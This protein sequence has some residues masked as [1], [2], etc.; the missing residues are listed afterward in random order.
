[1]LR[2]RSRRLPPVRAVTA[3]SAA[4]LYGCRR[5]ALE[6][7]V[8]TKVGRR[9]A[10]LRQEYASWYPTISI[11]SWLPA[12]TVARAVRRQLLEGEPKWAPRWQPGPRL[13]DDQH[14]QFR[15]GTQ[16][17]SARRTRIG[18]QPAEGQAGIQEAEQG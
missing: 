3:R 17:R 18:D 1:M 15:G 8:E 7:V 14:F 12:S 13:L 5:A 11:T 2:A 4:S 10:R 6:A 16:R 9:Q